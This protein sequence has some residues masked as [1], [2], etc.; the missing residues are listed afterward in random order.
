MKFGKKKN[1]RVVSN[2]WL[3]VML[4]EKVRSHGLIGKLKCKLLFET[5]MMVCYGKVWWNFSKCFSGWGLCFTLVG[6][7]CC[8][9]WLKEEIAEIGVTIAKKI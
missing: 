4:I 7:P 8:E 3:G 6:A 9:T 5:K 2:F 1:V